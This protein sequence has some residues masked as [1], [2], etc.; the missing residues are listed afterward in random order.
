MNGLQKYL[1][2]FIVFFIIGIGNL[3]FAETKIN[4]DSFKIDEKSKIELKSNSMVFN[5]ETNVTEFFDEVVVTYGALEL[6]SDKLKI[7]KS[8][9]LEFYAVGSIIISSGN[10]IITGQEAYF[11]TKNQTAIVSGSVTLS[12]GG[13]TI[14]GENLELNLRDGIAKILGSVKTVLTPTQGK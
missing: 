14:S 8:N 9:N 1:P 13:N 12:I 7:I 6:H 11:D 2:V 5:T 4:L 10:N 3:C